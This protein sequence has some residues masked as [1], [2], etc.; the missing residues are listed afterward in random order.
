MDVSIVVP[1]HNEE[2]YIE[3]CIRA[4]LL[5][6]YDNDRYEILMV[7]N[8]S[9]DRS[10]EIVS[11]YPE[12]QLFHEQEPGDFAARNLGVAKAS[13]KLIAFTDS[14]TAPLP[15]WLG[16]AVHVMHDPDSVLVVG[17]L[18]FSSN[19]AGMRLVCDYEAEKNRFIFSSSDSRVYYGYTCNMIVRRSVFEQL[20]NFPNVF[21]NSDVVYVRKVV[22]ALSNDAVCYGDRV[23]VR[24]LE[25]TNYW[26]YVSKQYVYGSDLN[27][28]SRFAD[29][30]PLNTRERFTVFSRAIHRYAYSPLTA[31]YL[32]ALLAVAAISYK[33]G[34]FIGVRN[35]FI[36]MLPGR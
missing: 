21:R 7:N 33:S 3:E 6:N 22:D 25:I 29:V 18:Q 4:L 16:Q 1:F 8:N 17:N 26:D 9:T 11:A 15:D 19:S 34:R 28:Y 14:D 5:Q 13:G 32:L 12:V 24:R 20:G 10:V 35:R 30:R 31:T 23:R 27:R 36:N 2:K